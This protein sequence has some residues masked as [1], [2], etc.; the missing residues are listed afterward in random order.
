[1]KKLLLGVAIISLS[2]LLGCDSETLTMK[3]T[4]TI[5]DKT[6]TNSE[7][8]LKVEVSKDIELTI[9]TQKC[10]FKVGDSIY[11]KKDL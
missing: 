6:V 9:H 11:V 8:I 1:M 2:S 7:C 4:G 5:K 10:N 3:M